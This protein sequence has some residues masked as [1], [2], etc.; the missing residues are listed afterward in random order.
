[1]DLE[2]ERVHALRE[3]AE[4]PAILASMV[5]AVSDAALDFHDPSGGWS[6]REILA[7][8]AD[9]EF[10]LHWTARVARVL[11]EER[12]VIGLVDS[13]EADWRALEHR[14]ANQDPRVAMGAFTMARKN[15]IRR[16]A[17]AAAEDWLRA[18]VDPEGNAKTVLQIAQGIVR[19][20]RR[21]LHRM[22]EL[23]EKAGEGDADA[24]TRQAGF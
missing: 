5:N 7:H 23:I 20:D 22:K 3:L 24:A 21:H 1:M 13:A 11:F 18:A 8:L 6:A 15:L 16:L 12:P 10:N 19:H 14:Y 17:A 2:A 4:G 9:M